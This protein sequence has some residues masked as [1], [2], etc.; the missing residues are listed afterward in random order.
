MLCCEQET[1]TPKLPIGGAQQYVPPPVPPVIPPPVV[2]PPPVIQPPPVKYESEVNLNIQVENEELAADVTD[3]TLLYQVAGKKGGKTGY[4]GF[5]RYGGKKAGRFGYGGK[6]GVRV[7][8]AE[9]STVNVV[10]ASD[11]NFVAGYGGKKGYGKVYAT[12]V[13]TANVV[14]ASNVNVVKTVPV[15][16]VQ[17]NV[18]AGKGGKR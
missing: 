17:Y 12:E 10:P 1:A 16:Q 4:M 6:K 15:G 14:P 13:V 3:T 2:Q 7:Y 5:D 11:V 18:R 8:A 9:V